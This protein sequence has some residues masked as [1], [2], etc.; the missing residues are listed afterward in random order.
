[1]SKDDS[2]NELERIASE[3]THEVTEHLSQHKNPALPFILLIGT[4]HGNAEFDLLQLCLIDHLV[5][6]GYKVAVGFEQPHN[7]LEKKIKSITNNNTVTLIHNN[8]AE[9]DQLTIKTAL[10]H[11][12]NFYSDLSRKLLLNEIIHKKISSRFNDAALCGW[13]EL[14]MDDAMTKRVSDAVRTNFDNPYVSAAESDGMQIRNRI[15]AENVLEHAKEVSAD[16]YIQ[17]CGYEHIAGSGYNAPSKLSLCDLFNRA[18][19]DYK[20]IIPES[21]KCD[22]K[23]EHSVGSP[24]RLKLNPDQE[25]KYNPYN[26]DAVW[27]RELAFVKKAFAGASKDFNY[28]GFASDLKR[29]KKE[30]S[31]TF[32]ALKRKPS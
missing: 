2:S 24:V 9:V 31:T 25:F 1:M 26:K 13:L 5:K 28:P 8:Q 10:S 21:Y 27:K 14:D 16:I 11:H 29:Y 23:D 6:A 3:V 32:G 22:H 19:A 30:I 15:I 20:L 7:F 12:D 17:S 4:V 18:G